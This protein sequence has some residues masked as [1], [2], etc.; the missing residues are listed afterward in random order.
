M[1][2][3]V[4]GLLGAGKTRWIWEQ[5]TAPDCSK[6]SRTELL[7]YINPLTVGVDASRLLLDVPH[8]QIEADL[9]KAVQIAESKAIYLERPDETL[10][11]HQAALKQSFDQ[12]YSR[13]EA[14]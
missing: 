8:L 7:L 3:V 2:T 4:A 6:Q 12:T 5:M 14:A 11:S 10:A 1:L 9:S 13:P